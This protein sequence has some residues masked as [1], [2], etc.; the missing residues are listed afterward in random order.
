MIYQDENLKMQFK[1]DAA[2][3]RF[4][5]QNLSHS[6]MSVQWDKVSLGV[7]NA[8]SLIRHSINMYADT[9]LG[10]GS[11]PIPPLGYIQDLI[12]PLDNV[13]FDGSQWV[14]SD[15]FQ[16][17]DGGKDEMAKAIKKN[18]GKSI[19]LTLPLQIGS[20]SKEYRFE[21]RIISVKRILWKD[22]RPPKPIPPPPK[23]KTR[24]ELTEQITTA[25]FIV[26]M[27]GF[28]AFMVSLKKQPVSE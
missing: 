13:F 15:L 8:Y 3:V 26:G 7:N 19:M 17:T 5:L 10:K 12:I 16:T 24:I 2:F 9:V 21:F 28:V 23:K 25:I 11:V 20:S 4:Q 18:V 6:V 27:L 22:Y 14:Q 1:I